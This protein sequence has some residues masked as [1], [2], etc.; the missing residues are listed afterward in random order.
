MEEPRIHFAIN[1]ASFSCPRLFNGAYT[2]SQMEEQLQKATIEFIN[3]PSKNKI[4]KNKVQLS[5]IFRWFKGDFTK[6]GSLIDYV[7]RYS[8]IEISKT[9]KIGYLMYDWGLNEAR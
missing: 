3:D 6:N 4:E 7:N 8:D 1:C 2:A 9:S 5:K